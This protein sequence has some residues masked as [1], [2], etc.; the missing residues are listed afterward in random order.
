MGGGKGGVA[1][2]P[3]TVTDQ[4]LEEI[5]VNMFAISTPILARI[6]IPAPDVNTNAQIIDWMV[7]EYEN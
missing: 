1:F 5:N 3:R 2:D 4:E 6:K 7:D